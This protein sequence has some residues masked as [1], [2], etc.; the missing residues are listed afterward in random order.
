VALKSAAAETPNLSGAIIGRALY[1]GSLDA[2]SAL[3]A[4]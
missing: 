1:D 4:C 3:A 2:A